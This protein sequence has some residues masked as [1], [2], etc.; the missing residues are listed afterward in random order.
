MRVSE[1]MTRH[2][3]VCNPGDSI[4][5]CANVMAEIGAGVLPV[6]ENS[7]LVGMITENDIIRIWPTLIEVTREYARAGL[8]SQFAKGIEGHC[9][10][11]GVYS[12]NLMWDRNLLAC[13]EC[14][15]G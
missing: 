8:D 7:L 15:G 1:A 3:R 4:R 9:E 5:D 14:R 2:V 6:A 11:C 13:P 10:V 12:T